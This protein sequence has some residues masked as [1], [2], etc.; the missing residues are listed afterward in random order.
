[1]AEIGLPPGT[2]PTMFDFIDPDEGRRHL[3]VKSTELA[4][5]IFLPALAR[6]V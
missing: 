4:L 3:D 2:V 6:R 5:R 1:M